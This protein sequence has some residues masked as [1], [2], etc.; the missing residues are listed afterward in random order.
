MNLAR[1]RLPTLA[2]FSAAIFASFALSGC[3]T[4]SIDN[5]T[6]ISYSVK[7]E[8]I[9]DDHHTIQVSGAAVVSEAGIRKV[10]H[11]KAAELSQGR[12]YKYRLT[13]EPY[14]YTSQGGFMA[15]GIYI[16]QTYSHNALRGSGYIYILATKTGQ[17]IDLDAPKAEAP[18]SAE[19]SPVK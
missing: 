11:E 18:A 17:N 4:G 15:G 16:P 5:P 10:F 19:A 12:D 13:I 14:T 8:K 3:A 2:I 1:S 6:A 7:A 9:S